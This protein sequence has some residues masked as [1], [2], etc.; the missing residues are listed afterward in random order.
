MTPGLSF[1]MA[2]NSEEQ[3]KLEDKAGI[4]P[5]QNISLELPGTSG[6]VRPSNIRHVYESDGIHM[7]LMANLPCYLKGPHQ[8]TEAPCGIIIVNT[9]VQDRLRKLCMH[10]QSTPTAR[11][12]GERC[13]G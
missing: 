10:V 6:S 11:M 8:L 3:R 7:L 5:S 1:A 4:L 12:T 9:Q 2:S 13:I